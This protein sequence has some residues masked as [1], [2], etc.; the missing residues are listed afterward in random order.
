MAHNEY[1]PL[2]I[3]RSISNAAYGGS[4]YLKLS[5]ILPPLVAA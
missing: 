1:F 4:P 5:S 3:L 2:S